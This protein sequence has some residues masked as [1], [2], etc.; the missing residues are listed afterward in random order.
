MKYY[1]KTNIGR[2][3]L[4][5]LFSI[6]SQH[7]FSGSGTTSQAITKNISGHIESSNRVH[8]LIYTKGQIK[9]VQQILYELG[10]KP[11]KVDGL[12]GKKTRKAIRGFQKTH[13]LKSDGLLTD[14]LFQKLHGY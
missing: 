3:S 14:H 10:Y 6:A 9:E 11:G 5:I 12:M 4:F 1:S 13:K 7:V 2:L 8:A